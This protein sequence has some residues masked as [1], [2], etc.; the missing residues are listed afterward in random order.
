MYLAMPVTNAFLSSKFVSKLA[1]GNW[2]TGTFGYWKTGPRWLGA[3][4]THCC[5]QMPP[6]LCGK[7]RPHHPLIFPPPNPTRPHWTRAAYRQD[8][9]P[10]PI[11][12]TPP[13]PGNK[14][15]LTLYTPNSCWKVKMRTAFI[16]QLQKH[17]PEGADTYVK[18][19]NCSIFCDRE[20]WKSFKCPL[21][22]KG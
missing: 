14:C 1:C 5:Q 8:P 9:H 12:V 4:G 15:L 13:G 11:R 7:L 22:V 6:V 16:Q 2:R 19:N 3:Q 21:T 17:S 18:G 10:L 20:N